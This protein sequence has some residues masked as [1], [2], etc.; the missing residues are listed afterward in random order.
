MRTD[1]ETGGPASYLK[2]Q[3]TNPWAVARAVPGEAEMEYQSVLVVDDAPG[4]PAPLAVRLRH[5]RLRFLH[6]FGTQGALNLARAQRPDLILLD[7]DLAGLPGLALCRELRRD[8]ELA[9]IPII[10]LSG[11]LEVEVK[12]KA[13]EAGAVDYVTKPFDAAELQARV[14]AA[15]RTKRY[16]DQLVTRAQRDGLTGLWNRAY[17]DELLAAEA[18]LASRHHRPVSLILFD[19]D[20]FKAL[21]DEHGHPFGDEVLQAVAEAVTAVLRRGE[22]ACRYGGEEFAIILRE[23]D[24]VGA[25]LTAE[26][27]RAAIAGLQLVSGGQ[28][29]EVTASLGVSCLGRGS[30]PDPRG[31]RRGGRGRPGA[32]PRQAHR[33]RSGLREGREQGIGGRDQGPGGR[34]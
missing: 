18:A 5:D 3:P 30:Q 10:V 6:A 26:R 7:L 11:A 24:A 28:V 14:Q 4:Y 29:V 13:F 23:T 9:G 1:N 27:V 34:A 33:A 22:I 17:F 15:L 31:L 2:R 16:Q 8:P 32:L 20:H 21:N 25:A 19:L 12:V